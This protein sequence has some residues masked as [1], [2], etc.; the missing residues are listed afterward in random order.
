MDGTGKIYLVHLE[1]SMKTAMVEVHTNVADLY[2]G[3]DWERSAILVAYQ[4]EFLS[5]ILDF[6]LLFM[7]SLTK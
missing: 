2:I 3:P 7:N 1:S 6:C 5:S 4:G